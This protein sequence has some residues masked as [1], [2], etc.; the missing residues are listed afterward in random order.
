MTNFSEHKPDAGSGANPSL[1]FIGGAL[2]GGLI[3]DGVKA[4]YQHLKNAEPRESTG[5]NMQR[6]RR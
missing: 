5:G 4:A 2:V 1:V 6:G 3:Y